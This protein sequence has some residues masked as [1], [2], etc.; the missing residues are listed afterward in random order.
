VDLVELSANLASLEGE[1]WGTIMLA[2]HDPPA[3]FHHAD[4]SEAIIA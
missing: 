4:V 1:E 2:L 3:P